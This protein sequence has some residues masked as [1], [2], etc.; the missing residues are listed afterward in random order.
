MKPSG[1]QN[2]N[3]L[4]ENAGLCESE[5]KDI[6]TMSFDVVMTST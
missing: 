6:R 5:Q 2:L 4:S 1:F 3:N